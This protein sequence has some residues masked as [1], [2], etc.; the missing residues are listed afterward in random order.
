[1]NPERGTQL[2]YWMKGSTPVR[3]SCWH[4]T[5]VA[6]IALGH[7]VNI[8]R[9]QYLSGVA[10]DSKLI[11]VNVYYLVE[12]SEP[13]HGAPICSKTSES[14]SLSALEWIYSIRH[15]FKIASVNMSLGGGEYRSQATC[16]AENPAMK[17]AIDNL[18]SVGIA[19]IVSA[20][21]SGFTDALASPACISSAISVGSISA[22]QGQPDGNNCAG[23]LMGQAGPGSISCFSNSAS[24]LSLLAPGDWI[25]SAVHSTKMRFASMAGTS[26]ASPHVAGAWAI[27]RQKVPSASVAKILEALVKT[28]Y[29]VQDPRNGLVKPVIQV[30]KAI[31]WVNESPASVKH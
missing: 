14:L 29:P 19:T 18:R 6:G 25:L 10:R 11:A 26:M 3:L 2:R 17:A 21:N 9:G 31:N 28:G 1:M 5:H 8:S 13:C 27:L 12:G 24:F 23:H 4:G 15:R 16:D 30:S 20:G 22:G 7:R